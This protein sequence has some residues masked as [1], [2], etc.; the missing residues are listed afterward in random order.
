M[1]DLVLSFAL[2]RAP[3]R[4]PFV[5]N[6]FNIVADML[7]IL[8]ARATKENKFQGI[9][10][11]LVPEGLSI[12]QYADDTVVFLDHNLQH[13]RNIKLFLTIFEQMSR[14]KINFHKSEL[15]CY[16][17]AKEY[18]LQYSHLFSYGIGTL[19]FKSLGIPMIHRRLRNS[20]W[21]GVIDRF[22]K[23]LSTWKAKFLSS[24]RRLILLNAVLSSLPISMMSFFELPMGMLKKLDTI[25]SRFF[26]QGENSKMKYRL[27]RWHVVYQPKAL[28]GLGVSNLVLKI[29][30]CSANGYTNYLMRMG[31][32]NNYSKIN[33]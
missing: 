33:T 28:G 7:A 21:Q 14:L 19:P 20:D 10:P 27:A 32:G 31:C 25:R 15:F 9:V 12:L 18:E 24:G 23:R 6:F 1:M 5:A 11:H 29:F 30:A 17:L 4:G 22:E 16:G 13:A 26:W 8:F 2:L 3:S